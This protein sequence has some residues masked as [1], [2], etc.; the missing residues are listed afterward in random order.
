[1]RELPN[2]TLLRTLTL[3]SLSFA[4]FRQRALQVV[5]TFANGTTNGTLVAIRP[6]ATEIAKRLR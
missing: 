2:V 4:T 5:T 3:V 1:M 6:A